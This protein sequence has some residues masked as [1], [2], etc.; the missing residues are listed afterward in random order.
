MGDKRDRLGFKSVIRVGLAISNLG[1]VG[2][3]KWLPLR[4]NVLLN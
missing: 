4:R 1:F 2:A 3:G